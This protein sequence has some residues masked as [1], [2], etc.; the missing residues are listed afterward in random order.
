MSIWEVEA[1]EA[2]FVIEA[3]DW[4]DAAVEVLRRVAPSLDRKPLLSCALRGLGAVDVHDQSSGLRLRMRPRGGPRDWVDA[5]VGAASSPIF[6]NEDQPYV[7]CGGP[8]LEPAIGLRVV[9]ADPA[10]AAA[11][12][13]DALGALPP[14]DL[15]DRLS[16]AVNLL[17]GAT[18]QAEAAQLALQLLRTFVPAESGAVLLGGAGRDHLEFVA[19]RGP[20]ADALRRRKLRI[21]KGQGI[22]GF[23]LAS[24]ASLMIRDAGADT[25]HLR[26]A[27]QASGYRTRSVL[28]VPIHEADGLPRWGVLELLNAPE[29]FLSWHVECATVFAAVLAELFAGLPEGREVY[30]AAS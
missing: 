21:P 16:E 7:F 27:D 25:R 28:A 22:A 11:A 18:T 12:E 3:D 1:D 13:A 17:G 19:L 4:M 14:A 6:L 15:E 24:G 9:S 8:P 29:G 2:V 5:R 10:V 20:R 23:V 30:A 26:A